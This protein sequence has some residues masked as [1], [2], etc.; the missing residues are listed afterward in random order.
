[1]RPSELLEINRHAI[2]RLMASYPR[3]ANLRVFGSVARGEDTVGSDIDFLVDTLPGATL[4]DL[5]GLHEDLVD[6][7]GVEIDII[8]TQSLKN[9]AIRNAVFRDVVS[10]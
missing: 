5:G 8:T 6:M 3:L 2:R 9:P 4:F 7:L 10:I 1:M